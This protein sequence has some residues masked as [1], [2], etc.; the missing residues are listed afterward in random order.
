MHTSWQA[1]VGI[2][3]EGLDQISLRSLIDCHSLPD[4]VL[5][6]GISDG[7]CGLLSQRPLRLKISKKGNFSP[8]FDVFR[9]SGGDDEIG[10]TKFLYVP[11]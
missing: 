6:A 7:M 4:Y 2:K 3:V 5:H 9:H 11:A 1:K 10:L 8:F